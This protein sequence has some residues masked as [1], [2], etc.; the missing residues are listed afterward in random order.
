MKKVYS[1][2]KRLIRY[3]SYLFAATLLLDLAYA[4][5]SNL[6]YDRQLRY[7]S[8]AALE[9]YSGRLIQETNRLTYVDRQLA[10]SSPA[11]RQAAAASVDDF[12]S[13][14]LLYQ[15]QSLMTA[16]VPD[17][18]LMLVFDDSGGTLRY[19]YGELVLHNR[20]ILG[21]EH[22]DAAHA[23][24][25][26]CLKAPADEL[27]Q[28]LILKCEPFT[29]L[30]RTSRYQ[31]LYICS[32]LE[33]HTFAVI[34]EKN[35]EDGLQLFFDKDGRFITDTDATKEKGLRPESVYGL[36]SL[37]MNHILTH[38]EIPA[39][40]IGLNVLMPKEGVWKFPQISLM[41][42]ITVGA[43]CAMVFIIAYR[44]MNRF[45]IYPLQQ[46]SFLSRQ[47]ADVDEKD[48]PRFQEP[49]PV[50]E[51]N[52]LR[53]SLNSLTAQKVHLRK[54][55]EDEETEKEHALL[56]YYQLQTR[57]HFFLNCLKSLYGMLETRNYARMQEMIIAFSNHLRYIF[58]DNLSLVP[59][60]AEMDEVW[61]YH[62]IIS[63]DS[64]QPLLL[65]QEI[66]PNALRCL[67]PPLIVQ[68]F[69]E[70]SY[71]YNGRGREAMNFTVRI[72]RIDYENKER[73][74]IRLSDDGLGYSRE[75]LDELNRP[76][77]STGF[78]QYH[79]G[80]S[81]LRR[82]MSILFKGDCELAFFNGLSGGAN[83]LISI[84]VQEEG[85]EEP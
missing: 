26:H 1:A 62:H 17:T 77:P 19:V 28:W 59:L 57:S 11:F 5:Y 73:L 23:L 70:N 14:A 40:G 42:T 60:Q 10:G 65:T 37:F 4:T 33:L 64:R 31:H 3:F 49:A 24:R 34:T 30:Y 48:I 76:I 80:I 63:M 79:I 2:R 68:T 85:E 69:L 78:T 16:T 84:P 32:A 8:D 43:V 81:N 82:R 75:T 27:D 58:H 56:Q 6:L 66:A 25:D 7:C 61:D 54:K 44:M 72:D 67:V 47:M 55:H 18:G 29:F 74:R 39:L 51:L 36:G 50:E 21:R 71:K 53:E 20:T 35:E 12:T 41:V 15:I 45:M 83:V 38:A 22:I 13:I 9:L 46:I 52:T